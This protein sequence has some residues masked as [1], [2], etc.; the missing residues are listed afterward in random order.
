[1]NTEGLVYTINA[2]GRTLAAMEQQIAERDLLIT[3]FQ[4][5]IGETEARS[6]EESE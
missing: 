1:M 5:K 3:Q 2:L 6:E 4:S